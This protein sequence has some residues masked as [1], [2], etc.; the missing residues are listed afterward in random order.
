MKRRS[1][2][3]TG[4]GLRRL[5]LALLLLT[6][7]L[8]V[9]WGRGPGFL[10]RR[11]LSLFTGPAERLAQKWEGWRT[12]R[13]ARIRNL[14]A[15]EAEV[16]RL[17]Q[18]LAEAQ[19]REAQAAPRLT[20]AEEAVR[21]L[22][23]SRQLPLELKSARVLANTRNAPFGG[24]LI[25]RGRD[26]DLKE[27]QGVLA[28]EGVVGRIWQVASTQSTVLPLDA[29]N[30]S[31]AVMLGRSRA[32]GVLQGTGPGRAEIRYISSQ[33]VVQAGE[34]VYTSGLDRVFP[35]G[36]L[37]GYV[38]SQKPKDIELRIEVNLAV[39]L[40]RLHLVLVLPSNPPLELLPAAAAPGAP[41]K[42]VPP[43]AVPIPA[44]GAKE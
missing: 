11:T 13:E 31:T 22:G 40:D 14:A 7:L 19:V 28:P 21:I 41:A 4:A 26:L 15:A 16:A 12:A 3:F 32:T 36:L 2:I 35:R 42:A 9:I 44:K 33:E 39:P 5:L 6:H 18:L 17:R 10:V 37:V 30:A 27:D 20:E 43:A 23:L 38:A 8:W 24:L 34:P 1:A 25:D 29:Y